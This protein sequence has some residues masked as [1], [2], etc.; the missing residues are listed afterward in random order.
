MYYV[1]VDVLYM[2]EECNK[3][4]LVPVFNYQASV[5]GKL[6]KLK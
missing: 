1:P 6:V 5:T 4:V 3:L 2:Y